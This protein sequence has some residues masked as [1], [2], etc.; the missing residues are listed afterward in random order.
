MNSFHLLR[1]NDPHG[2]HVHARLEQT[3]SESHHQNATRHTLLWS[4]TEPLFRG[5]RVA[6]KR[7][8]FITCDNYPHK[9]MK[10][11][12]KCRGKGKRRKEAVETNLGQS[13]LG[14]YEIMIIKT[15]ITI[16]ITIITV[17]NTHGLQEVQCAHGSNIKNVGQK[18]SWIWSIWTFYYL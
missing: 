17:I 15:V 13:D 12:E 8:I 18:R 5:V 11:W 14:L 7:S 3:P 9:S 16:M 1:I 10:K 2:L 6:V 4:R